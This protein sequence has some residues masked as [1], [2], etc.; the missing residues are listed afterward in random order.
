M[1]GLIHLL[2]LM[3]YKICIFVKHQTLGWY[4]GLFD[5]QHC[6][7]RYNSNADTLSQPA[8]P[9]LAETVNTVPAPCINGG[10][11]HAAQQSDK[12]LS[13]I[14]KYLQG[15]HFLRSTRLLSF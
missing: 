3:F 11:L 8:D 15:C 6:P 1:N 9:Q 10:E 14:I 2:C 7:G 5:V 4:I 13:T 12:K